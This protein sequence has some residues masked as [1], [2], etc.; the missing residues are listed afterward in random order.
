M[1][2][3]GSVS[4]PSL[5]AAAG[6]A[7]ARDEVRHG[8]DWT[9][10]RRLFGY[11]DRHATKRRIVLVT[12]AIRA[13]QRPLHFWALA[14]VINGPIARG[15][16]AGTVL[17]AL[18][19][20]L[21]ALSTALV[22]HFRSRHQNELGELLVHDL[23][24]D[25][26][27]G[28]QRQPMGY[29]HK[30]KLGRI[31]SRMISDLESARRGIQL[32]VFIGQEFLQLAICGGLML[33]HNWLLFLVMLGIGPLLLWSNRHF[34][35]RLHRFTRAAAE[36]SSRLTGALA[37]SVR[38]VRVIQSF[39]RQ[40][41]GEEN[42]AVHANRLAE[43]NVRL[44]SESALYAPVLGLTG[45]IF[46]AA[47]LLV[48]GY[49]ALH[50][51]KGLDIGSLIAFFFLPTSFFMSLQAAASYY[52]QIIAA[53]VGA[54][55]VLELID[56]KPEWED[57]PDATELPDP[58]AVNAGPAPGARVEFRDVSFGYDP[59]RLV[60]HGINLVAAPGQT[61]AL[62]GHTGSGKS[63]IVNLVAKFYRPGRGEIFVDGRELNTLR[64]E[65]LRRQMG[66][67]FQ[68]N[69]LFTGTVRE[70]IRFGRPAATDAEVADAAR[71]LDC[72]DL[73]EGLPEGLATEVGEGGAN[74]SLGQRQLVCFTRAL[75]ANP[76]ILI[77]DEA[78]SAV[79][80]VTE[81]RL[82][83]ALGRLLAG[84][85]SFVVAH[86]LSTVVRADQIIVL[87]RG[88]IIERGPHREL[89]VKRGAYWRLY[90]EFVF[91]GVLG[92]RAEAA[93]ETAGGLVENSLTYSAG[94]LK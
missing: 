94:A 56:L 14:A 69:F 2:F 22:L 85:T 75:L 24:N 62:V 76:R 65:S 61:V 57:A 6:K 53:Q 50:G 64:S 20:L 66:I 30:T 39:T 88:R 36:S 48:G 31:L 3:S 13:W 19:F 67:V 46:L 49:G 81:R 15:D 38:G 72:L 35:P 91:A 1:S 70:N 60:L 16:W 58:R 51:F 86:R 37:E 10:F 4:A 93:S 32:V 34:H 7:P 18:G 29:F 25:L 73:L 23:R 5:A 82:Q 89:L 74:L 27:A 11:T 79:D 45:Q 12:T 42:F 44:A 26:F 54:E 17:G 47:M 55:R 59:E 21:L 43:D 33:Y 87:D 41:R 92:R 9:L 8:F 78:T 40:G 71:R 90:R 77:L 52:P 68:T 80:P 63:T 83:H 28:L 84:R